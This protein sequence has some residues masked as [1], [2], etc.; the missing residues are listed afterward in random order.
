MPI[1]LLEAGPYVVSFN[2]NLEML[3]FIHEKNNFHGPDS[4]NKALAKLGKYSQFPV[5]YQLHTKIDNCTMDYMKYGDVC[6]YDKMYTL[7]MGEH[8]CSV[9][10]LPKKST[11]C[12]NTTISYKAMNTYVRNQNTENGCP[13]FC[14]TT[15]IFLDPPFVDENWFGN[16]SA[17]IKFYFKKVIK[18]SEEYYLYNELSLF[19]NIGGLLGLMLGIS[20]VNVRDVIGRMLEYLS[21]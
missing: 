3:V 15:D 11:I 16:S 7:L 9:P 18:N 8:N 20:L 6:F 2:F 17:I 13:S 10:W 12:T 1:C 19:A 5:M 4:T 21:K 14:T